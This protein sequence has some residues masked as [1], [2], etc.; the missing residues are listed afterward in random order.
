MATTDSKVLPSSPRR[1]L[2]TPYFH[3]FRDDTASAAGG[4]P[5][6]SPICATDFIAAQ[7]H[8][9]APLNGWINRLNQRLNRSIEALVNGSVPIDVLTAVGLIRLQSAVCERA[10]PADP[11]AQSDRQCWIQV[12][13]R[14][15]SEERLRINC[16]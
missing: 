2:A 15:Q 12:N 7:R 6:P 14:R 11:V 8:E 3:H 1:P 13:M 9:L 16:D 10:R 4:V 5:P